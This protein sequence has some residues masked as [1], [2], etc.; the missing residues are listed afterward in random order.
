MFPAIK[1]FLKR[2]L[3]RYARLAAIA[4]LPVTALGS[5]RTGIEWNFSAD[6]SV[7]GYNI[8]YGTNS[9]A[10]TKMISVG[11]VSSAIITNV[12]P[13]ITY[14]TA[15][16]SHNAA[17]KEGE[18]S[19]EASFTY[20]SVA[21]GGGLR[22]RTCRAASGSSQFRFSLAPGAPAG[23]KINPTN[24]V[25]SWMPDLTDANAAKL[26]QVNITDLANPSVSTQQ[27]LLIYVTDFFRLTLD[28]VPVQS[29][30][31]ASLTLGT[32]ASE[33]FT[34]LEINLRWP[35][36]SL[37][38]PALTFSPL[39]AGGSLQHSGTNLVIK[40]W[41]TNGAVVSGTNAFAQINFQAAAGQSSAFLPVPATLVS[42][43]KADGSTFVS[44]GARDGEVVIIGDDPLLRPQANADLSR[45]L[46]IYANPG[47]TYE[48]QAS[49]NLANPDAWQALQNY[50]PTNVLQT[51]SLDPAPP[52]IFYRLMRS[53][54]KAI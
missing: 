33:G 45:A 36:N 42:A 34:N 37:L 25:L 53:E 4:A 10:Y 20:Y 44:G 13:G 1:R 11:Q 26:I 50:Q 3:F 21:P 48:L 2:S 40:L 24:G 8:Y 49:T 52:V 35:G 5:V 22:V 16:K 23:A 43:S 19:S 32:L 29:G 30:Q 31:A 12:L 6:P 39:V 46:T 17:G 9:F 28:S 27:T 54:P 47:F 14:Y 15:I 38:N 41:T 18:F 51:F 7:T